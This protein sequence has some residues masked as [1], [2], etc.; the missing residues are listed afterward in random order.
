MTSHGIADPYHF[1]GTEK[2]CT[3]INT[4][5]KHEACSS[6]MQK[7]PATVIYTVKDSSYKDGK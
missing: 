1:I 7:R 3:S 4:S 6:Q 2:L 5:V